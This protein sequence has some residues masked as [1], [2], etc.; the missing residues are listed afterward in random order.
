[1]NGAP[2]PIRY[3][4]TFRDPRTHQVEVDLSV[5][6]GGAPSV[7]LYLPVWTPGSY[8]VRDYARQVEALRAESAGGNALPVEKTRK[9]RWR[10][11]TWGAPRVHV[12]YRLYG[13]ELSVRTNF[14]DA[15][16]ALLNGA[17]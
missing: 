3:T 2:E 11:Q 15:G 7:E 4:L 1:M 13:R 6:T 14:V 12:A 17:A 9:N 10:V 16:F 5:P 8:K